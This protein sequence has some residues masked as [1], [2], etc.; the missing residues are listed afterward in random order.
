MA[1]TEH[2]PG[3]TLRALGD[4]L[5]PGAAMA[6]LLA[7][8]RWAEAL[9]DAVTRTGGSS[10]GSEWVEASALADLVLLLQAAAGHRGVSAAGS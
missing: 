5:A 10:L 2:S 3:D 7:E 1:R 8:H 9:A 6:A 4:D